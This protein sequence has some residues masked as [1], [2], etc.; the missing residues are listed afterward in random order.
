[1]TERSPLKVTYGV[2]LGHS[3]DRRTSRWRIMC[4]AET[5]WHEFEPPTTM[6]RNAEITCPRCKGS[7]SVDYD[8]LSP[9][10]QLS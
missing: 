7:L 4:P 9:P 5:C 10:P 3:R 2:W 8:E 6:F 1:M